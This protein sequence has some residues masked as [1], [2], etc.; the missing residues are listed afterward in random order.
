[1]IKAWNSNH[2]TAKTNKNSKT[3]KQTNKQKEAWHGRE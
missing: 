2:S 1:V 3:K